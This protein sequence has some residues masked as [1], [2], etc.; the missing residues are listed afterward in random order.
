VSSRRG[1]WTEWRVV[2]MW[3]VC[4]LW[5]GPDE[6]PVAS[7]RAA[8]PLLSNQPSGTV[9]S[10]PAPSLPVSVSTRYL[11]L[12][13]FT[14]L[15]LPHHRPSISHT[16]IILPIPPRASHSKISPLQCAISIAAKKTTCT[17]ARR[18]HSSPRASSLSFKHDECILL[19][20]SSATDP[21]R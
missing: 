20:L 10:R 19:G 13:L 3:C 15:S 4:G 14:T 16:K 12:L 6:H 8:R 7:G 17:F 2:S 9:Q 18:A 5:A 21:Q 11:A 1:W